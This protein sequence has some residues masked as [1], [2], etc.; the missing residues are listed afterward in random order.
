PPHAALPAPRAEIVAP[1]VDE[2][3]VLGSLLLV[4]EQLGGNARVLLVVASPPARAG[5]R[6]DAR[7]TPLQSHE[8]LGA[9]AEQLAERRVDE[10]HVRRRILAPQRAVKV[11]RAAVEVGAEP[12]SELQL[13]HVAFEDPALYL[14]H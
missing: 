6:T 5:E 1:Q 14:R 11:E 2:H 10:E 9:R 13:V 3:H 12:N 8:K 4:R 7:F